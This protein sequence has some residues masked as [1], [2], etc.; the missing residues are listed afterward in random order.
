M[1]FSFSKYTARKKEYKNLHSIVM[2]QATLVCSSKPDFVH[3]RNLLT[4]KLAF[5]ETYY[6]RSSHQWYKDI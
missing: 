4:A 3:P 6:A 1:T 5:P 2:E